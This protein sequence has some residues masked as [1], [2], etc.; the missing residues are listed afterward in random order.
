[1]KDHQDL[2]WNVFLNLSSEGTTCFKSDQPIS[3]RKVVLLKNNHN[4]QTSIRFSVSVISILKIEILLFITALFREKQIFL[5]SV[6]SLV[7]H[8]D[9]A[10]VLDQKTYDSF[11]IKVRVIH[12]KD[13]WK[14][15]H[16]IISHNK[17]L[18]LGNNLS[19]WRVWVTCGWSHFSRRKQE[20][21]L[22]SPEPCTATAKQYLS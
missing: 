3:K 15:M 20:S 12:I 2:V 4:E 21:V 16:S 18:Y 9:Q 13:R 1:M 5:K 22:H 8:W 10:V 14:S 6:S 17:V 19:F 11:S 7:G